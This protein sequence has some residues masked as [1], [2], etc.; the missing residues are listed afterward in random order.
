MDIGDI[1]NF[2]TVIKSIYQEHATLREEQTN[3]H[4]RLYN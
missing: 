2:F 3:I 1:D 4:D